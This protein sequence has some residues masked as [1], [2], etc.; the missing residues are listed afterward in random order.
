MLLEQLC[1]NCSDE[2]YDKIN[3]IFAYDYPETI[4]RIDNPELQKNLVIESEK[5]QKIME[6][7][8]D[9]SLSSKIKYFKTLSL[10]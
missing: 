2:S 9:P 1:E 4:Y 10:E 7:L 3:D 5:A 8:L 6:H